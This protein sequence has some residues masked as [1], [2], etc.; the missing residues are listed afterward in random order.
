MNGEKKLI[1]W[2]NI[3]YCIVSVI[4]LL[5]LLFPIY[6]IFV[7][8]IKTEQEIFQIP[9]TMWPHKLNLSS[10][11]AQL[12]SGDFNMFRSFGN[13]LFISVGAMIISII[14]AVPASYGVA[15]YQFKGKNLIILIFLI[16]QM[17]P[18]SVLL[19]PLFIMFRN[20]HL[21]NSLFSA[22]LADANH[23]Y[24]LFDFDFKELF[25]FNSW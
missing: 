1:G 11:A 22:V 5:I 14:L 13:S 10:Y 23:W 16:T 21:Y 12:K 17:L 18:V 20:M 25:C 19:T 2:K 24:S 9:P 3:V 15:K 7:T 4:L 8:S 6:W